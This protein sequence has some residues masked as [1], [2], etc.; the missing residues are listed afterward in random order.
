MEKKVNQDT[1]VGLA[2][3]FFSLLTFFFGL[4]IFIIKF[5]YEQ[6][7]LYSD[8]TFSCCCYHR[9]FAAVGVVAYNGYTNSDGAKKS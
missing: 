8:R 5:L 6:K 3:I 7:S 1:L 4:Y 9:Y 2:L